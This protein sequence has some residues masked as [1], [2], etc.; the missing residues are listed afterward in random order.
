LTVLFGL[1][2]SSVL[3]A[4]YLSSR[5]FEKASVFALVVESR[6]DNMPSFTPFRVVAIVLDDEPPDDVILRIYLRHQASVRLR[7]AN[8][9]GSAGK[10]ITA[11]AADRETPKA[12]PGTVP[13]GRIR[14][15][16]PEPRL[17]HSG[18][19]LGGP[20]QMAGLGGRLAVDTDGCVYAEVGAGEGL[21]LAW[22]NDYSARLGS[23]QRVEILDQTGHV[24]LRK[25]QLF[26]A[27]GG[28][29]PDERALWDTQH[30]REDHGRHVFCIQ[31]AVIPE[32]TKS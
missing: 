20:A 22:P 8:R 25:G 14:P 2:R 28:F 24:V 15:M 32:A 16:R 10:G 21:G 12:A 19:F 6:Y 11:S 26:R 18:S 23:D 17:V 9:G 5:C 31:T 1:G 13:G 3:A 30:E 4:R 27:A 29:G 7:N